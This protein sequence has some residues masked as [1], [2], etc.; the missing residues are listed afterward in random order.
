MRT[1]RSERRRDV[2]VPL[3]ERVRF[4]AAGMRFFGTGRILNIGK[5]GLLLATRQTLAVGTPL[6]IEMPGRGPDEY[7][8]LRA[9]VVRAAAQ[10]TPR[11]LLATTRRQFG[12]SITA[13]DDASSDDEMARCG[14]AH[15]E[16]EPT[17]MEVV[18]LS[19]QVDPLADDWV[20][21]A[22]SLTEI[23]TKTA[24]D[25]VLC[26][27]RRSDRRFIS[28]P[29]IGAERRHAERRQSPSPSVGDDSTRRRG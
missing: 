24:S 18:D 6:H 22:L 4:R 3:I 12:C 1:V 11:R 15:P 28:L 5:K 16:L 9:L 25:W 27:R 2:R 26:E 13:V 20:E 21:R 29:W 8:Q 17:A 10:G 19:Q 7:I 23:A 14:T